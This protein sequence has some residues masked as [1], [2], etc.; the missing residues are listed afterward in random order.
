MDAA[1]AVA[2]STT[3]GAASGS[4]AVASASPAPALIPVIAPAPGPTP[5]TQAP[6]VPVAPPASDVTTPG[7]P[8]PVG[9]GVVAPEPTPGE[10]DDKDPKVHEKPTPP[11]NGH[12]VS[13][14]GKSHDKP[15]LKSHAPKKVA[16]AVKS[17][18]KKVSRAAKSSAKKYSMASRSSWKK[19]SKPAKPA[20]HSSGKRSG[21]E[22]K[23]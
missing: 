13:N 21:A 9:G 19:Y 12:A 11:R 16:R 22:H 1:S 7:T 8:A 3:S 2:P 4:L 14:P 17:S 18:P 20:G 23:K 15:K 6:S 10:P 5:A